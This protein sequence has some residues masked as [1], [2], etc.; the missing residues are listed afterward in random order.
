MYRSDGH[1][2]DEGR[3]CR[4]TR[5][6]CGAA[7]RWAS[8]RSGSPRE[9]AATHLREGRRRRTGPDTTAT[10]RLPWLTRLAGAVAIAAAIIAG[11]ESVIGGVFDPSVFAFALGGIAFIVFGELLDQ[12]G[13]R[14]AVSDAVA[15]EAFM[16]ELLTC[17]RA[18][19]PGRPRR[20]TRHRSR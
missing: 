14:L 18:T 17:E 13:T 2:T 9:G 15:L 16:T 5:G 4:L 7:G 20:G 1:H 12:I 3:G 11:L 19:A 6:C 10:Y 8:G